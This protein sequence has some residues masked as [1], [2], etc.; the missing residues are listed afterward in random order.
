MVLGRAMTI[1][2]STVRDTVR[3]LTPSIGISPV[4]PS[5]RTQTNGPPHS[6]DMEL[7]PRNRPHRGD[8]AGRSGHAALVAPS[9]QTTPFE[10]DRSLPPDLD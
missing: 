6:S 1:V 3:T 8:R 5:R 2:A 10:A 4:E 7:R 9:T